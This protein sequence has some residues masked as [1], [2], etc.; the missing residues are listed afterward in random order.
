[1]LDLNMFLNNSPEDGMPRV[2]DMMVASAN[3]EM[4]MFEINDMV[5]LYNLVPLEFK[6]DN[7]ET[8]SCT[9]RHTIPKIII[10]YCYSMNCLNLLE[11]Y[12]VGKCTF[13][14]LP[15]DVKLF[16]KLNR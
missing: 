14:D 16:I 6:Q 15:D 10:E 5:M 4:F 12:F 7:F 1:M 2:I 9:Y 13:E 3:K 8:S 11:D